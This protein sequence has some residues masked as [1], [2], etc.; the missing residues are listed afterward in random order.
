MGQDIGHAMR[1]AGQR[2]VLVEVIQ[3]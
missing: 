1:P 2:R 3:G